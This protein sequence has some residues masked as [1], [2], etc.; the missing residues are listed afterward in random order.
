[1]Q[2]AAAGCRLGATC[3][4]IRVSYHLKVGLD[5]DYSPALSQH[6]FFLADTLDNVGVYYTQPLHWELRHAAHDSGRP[7]KRRG[8]MRVVL[9]RLPMRR[10]G[11]GCD[12]SMLYTRTSTEQWQPIVAM[13]RLQGPV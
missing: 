11:P 1:M 10:V 5:R 8:G 13:Q 4:I 3:G 2:L 6:C 12:M 7:Q 9:A